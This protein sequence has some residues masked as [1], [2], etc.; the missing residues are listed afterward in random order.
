MSKGVALQAVA[1]GVHP[2]HMYSPEDF[3]PATVPHTVAPF[4]ST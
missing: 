3:F 2:L 4:R 1:I